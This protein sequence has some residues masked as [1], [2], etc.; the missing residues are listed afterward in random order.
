MYLEVNCSR[1][2]LQNL[3]I[4]RDLSLKN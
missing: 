2:K 4:Y 1:N 3:K